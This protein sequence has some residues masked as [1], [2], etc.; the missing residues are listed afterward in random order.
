MSRGDGTTGEDILENLKTIK[1][2]PK[3][4]FQ[5]KYQTY[6]R[7]DVRFILE[8]KIFLK[9]KIV[10]QIQEMLQVVH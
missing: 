3:K 5:T 9:L 6:L 8:K 4:L 7:L 1:D 2:I 10:L